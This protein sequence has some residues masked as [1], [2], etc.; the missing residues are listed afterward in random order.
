VVAEIEAAVVRWCEGP[1]AS[2]SSR[3]LADPRVSV[4]VE[5]VARAIAGARGGYDAIALDL[6]EGP[7]GDAAER[8]H[9]IYGDAGLRAAA[10]ALRPGGVLAVWSEQAAPGFARRLE[11]RGFQVRME[12]SG[13]GGRRHPIYRAVRT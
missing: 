9:P 12:R 7:R 11:A 3:A 10:A 2:A 8:S 13:R 5:D 1:C 6:Y 4:R